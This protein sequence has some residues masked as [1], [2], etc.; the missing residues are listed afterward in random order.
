[1]VDCGAIAAALLALNAQGGTDYACKASPAGLAVAR[2]ADQANHYLAA[3]DSGHAAFVAQFGE[4]PG[5][6]AIIQGNQARAALAGPL[7]AA[8]Y[9][10]VLPWVDAVEEAQRRR[11]RI[12]AQ[13][14]DQ[15]PGLPE[16]QLNAL[17]ERALGGQGATDE[18]LDPAVEQAAIAHELGHLW[19]I[20]AFWPHDRDAPAHY[21]GH[22]PDWLD[23]MAAVA[24]EE[25]PLLETRREQ[26][27]DADGET[28]IALDAFLAMEHPLASLGQAAR[29]NLADRNNSADTAASGGMQVLRL[30]GEEADEFLS[31]AAI[32]PGSY[33]V[34]ARGFL[35]YLT[36]R[37]GAAPLGELS[38]WMR[39][40]GTMETWLAEHGA[41]HGLPSNTDL[42]V[43]DWQVWLDGA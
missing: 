12:R 6:A 34:M 26:L 20:D 7:E 9:E 14:E 38:T 24:M 28:P 43:A 40:G 16:A 31:Q 4:T 37:A 19:Y 10:R 25:G 39:G 2:D 18:P 11:D 23:E 30:S 36:A 15:A 5:P 29:A 21:G 33:Y 17:V 22:A 8:G 13:I 41:A 1:M 3:L 27:R 42:L 35:D 32:D